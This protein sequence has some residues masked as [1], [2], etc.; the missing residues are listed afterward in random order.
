[1]PCVVCLIF[2]LTVLAVVIELR[3]AVLEVFLFTTE[4]RAS[5]LTLKRVPLFFFP[6]RALRTL[7]PENPFVIRLTTI[8]IMGLLFKL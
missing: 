8:V 6:P 2:W 7:S 5:L 4:K 3:C 1:M